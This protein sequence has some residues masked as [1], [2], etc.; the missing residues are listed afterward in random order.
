MSRNGNL[1]VSFTFLELEA[2]KRSIY[3][4]VILC[5]HSI[6]ENPVSVALFSTYTELVA[7]C[8]ASSCRGQHAMLPDVM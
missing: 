7:Y 3:Q 6:W 5:W 1:A 2:P 8:P 4:V